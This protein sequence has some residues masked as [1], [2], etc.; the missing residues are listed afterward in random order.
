M[1]EKISGRQCRTLLDI[2]RTS[3]FN[4]SE[5]LGFGTNEFTLKQAQRLLELKLF[6]GINRK[7][8]REDFILKSPAEIEKELNDWG[9]NVETTMNKRREKIA[10][11]F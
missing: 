7:G 5:C 1:E 8:R 9:I 10:H 11:D 3:L 2:G 4:Y 6:L